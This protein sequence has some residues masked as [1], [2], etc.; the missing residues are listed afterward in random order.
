MLAVIRIR[1]SIGIRKGVEDTLIMLRLKDVNQCVLLAEKRDIK[2]MVE[3]CRDYITYGEVDKE[4]IMALLK[5]RLRQMGNKRVDE[6]ILKEI[7]GFESF[8]NFAD[9][10]IEGKNKLKDFEKLQQNFRLTPPS[11]G[12]NSIKEHYPKGDL[13]DRGKEISELLK[14]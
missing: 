13:G 11:K 4:T 8:E 12:F 9:A 7:T 3:K 6:K 14:R 1:G 5:K 10:I 2:G